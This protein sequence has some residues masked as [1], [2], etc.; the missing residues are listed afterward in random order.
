MTLLSTA[1]TRVLS[2]CSHARRRL[3]WA[4]L[5][6][7]LLALGACAAPRPFA[8]PDAL[9]K[10][11]TGD[12]AGAYPLDTYTGRLGL[13]ISTD[14]PQ[15]FSADFS[16]QG[17]EKAGTL[18]LAGPF[19]NIVAL[20]QWD[21]QGAQLLQQ[22]QAQRFADLPSLLTTLTGVAVPIAGVMEWLQGKG[23]AGLAGAGWV[24]EGNPDQTRRLKAER[25]NPLPTVRLVLIL[26]DAP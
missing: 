23:Y 5:C 2:F 12:L 20:V 21:A 10:A 17:T 13:T 1:T 8:S 19:G 11:G 26:D 25:R 15:N 14:T 16:L 22:G 3:I 9:A 24:L 4:G 6:A 18:Q 7:G